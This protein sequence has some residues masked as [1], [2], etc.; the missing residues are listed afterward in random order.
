LI[1]FGGTGTTALASA[2]H[3]P[4]PKANSEPLGALPPRVGLVEAFAFDPRNP[5]IVYLL[6]RGRV[7]KS[8]DGG[9]HWRAMPSSSW[10]G[11][12][13]TLAADPRH[14]GTL[15]A[16]TGLGVFKTVDGGRSWR[17]SNRGLFVRHFTERNSGWVTAL[18]VDPAN[19]SIVYAG[20]DR[21]NKSTDSG[22]SW[23][24][25]FTPEPTRNLNSI[26]VSALAIA[27]TRPETIYA[28]HANSLTGHTSI[29]TSTDAGTTWQVSIDIPGFVHGF[30]TDLAVDPH[31]PT[32]V[33]AAVGATVLK[34]A[35]AGNSWQA[36]GRGLPV[37]AGLPRG[38]CHCRNGVTTLAIDPHQRGAVYA[39]VNQG[40]I[41]K[42][43]NGGQNWRHVAAR[44]LYL[45]T[46]VGVDPERPTTVYGSAMSEYDNSIHLFRSSSA[47]RTWTTAP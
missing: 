9:A 45:T 10:A 29:Y 3:A 16:G 26:S 34:T 28:I 21:I 41:Y 25:V 46:I 8:T 17:R 4:S 12:Y 2:R 30:V 43:T 36:I 19:P 40:G 27:P 6:T 47:G 39:G 37:Q 32:T 44:G 38:G 11:A 15:Y 42:T 13:Q 33:Y 7:V 35:D 20:S 31:H 23:K 24:T 18:A 5:N 22:H 14:P 1:G